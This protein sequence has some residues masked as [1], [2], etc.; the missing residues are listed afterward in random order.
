MTPLLDEKQAA[1][2]LRMTSKGLQSWRYRGGGP[3]F[4]KAG[5]SVRYRLEDLQAFVLAAL[6]SSTSDPGPPAIPAHPAPV[7]SRKV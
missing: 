6:R 1:A 7:H 5:R 2:L 4:V 3:R